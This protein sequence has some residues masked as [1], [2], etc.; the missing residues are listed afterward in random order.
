MDLAKLRWRPLLVI[1]RGKWVCGSLSAE[2]TRAD[3]S[4]I[5]GRMQELANRQEDLPATEAAPRSAGTDL[6]PT[7]PIFPEIEQDALCQALIKTVVDGIVIIDQQGFIASFNPA[8]ERLFGYAA[9]EVIGQNVSRLMPESEASQHDQ[10]IRRYLA[11]NEVQIIGSGREVLGRRKDGTEF[12]VHLSIS[13]MR[14]GDHRL[15]I[16]VIHDISSLKEADRALRSEKERAESA[17]QFKSEF[18][19]NMSHEIRTPMNGI[20]GMTGL[21]VDTCL[22]AEQR[23]LPRTDS[24][25]R[26]RRYWRLINDILDFSKIEAGKLE[27]DSRPFDLSAT[28][29]EIQKLFAVR[30][31]QK[32]IRFTSRQTPGTPRQLIGDPLR[33]RQVLVNL[34]ENAMKFTR[35]GDVTCSVSMTHMA[36]P[37]VTLQFDIVDTGIG[38]PLEQQQDVFDVFTQVR[39]RDGGDYGGSGLGLPISAKLVEMMGGRIWFRS[40]PGKGTAFSFTAVFQRRGKRDSLPATSAQVMTPSKNQPLKILLAEDDSVNRQLAERFLRGA[41]HTVTSVQDG[42]EAVEQVSADTFDVILMDVQMPNLDGFAATRVIREQERGSE[43]RIPIV[44]MT[45]HA[46]LGD[47]DRCLEAGMDDYVSKPIKMKLLLESLQKV[48]QRPSLPAAGK[49]GDLAIQLVHGDT[50]LLSDLIKTFLRDCAGD[51]ACL[52]RGRSSA[53]VGPGG[54]GG[55]RHQRHRLR[56]RRQSLPTNRDSAGTGMPGERDRTRAAIVGGTGAGGR[57]SNRAP[58]LR[59][60]DD[61]GTLPL[62]R[63]SADPI[64]PV[65]RPVWESGCHWALPVRR[66][67]KEASSGSGVAQWHPTLNPSLAGALVEPIPFTRTRYKARRWRGRPPRRRDVPRGSCPSE[68]LSAPAA[69]PVPSA[70]S[71]ASSRPTQPTGLPR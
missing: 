36:D 71:A 12:P 7:P 35:T 1:F 38:I 60:P 22:D 40:D 21:L 68:S 13:E 46:M 6:R 31:R 49:E 66:W 59:R 61:V 2:T 65:L 39:R 27:I 53:T 47:R 24:Q 41:G 11:T 45:A 58:P 23:R 63:S 54:C 18:L 15:F 62:T 29:F 30:A 57:P 48:T 70:G 8:A 67:L 33:L 26:R 5:M 19:A 42:A 52:E 28:M 64:S 16:G 32:G 20:I 10:H 25:F 55:P 44:A 9:E 37:L 14:R 17:N 3:G 50:E 51:A 56:F 69:S 43:R 4:A 34:L